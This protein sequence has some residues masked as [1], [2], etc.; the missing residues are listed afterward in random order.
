MG[1]WRLAER[2]AAHAETRTGVVENAPTR[3]LATLREHE[4]SAWLADE[5]ESF[6]EDHA[7]RGTAELELLTPRWAD[8]PTP[9]LSSFQSYARNPEQNS[10]EALVDR[11]RLDREAAQREV[12]AR[13]TA[14][15]WERAF[16]LRRAV[17]RH[18]AHWARRYAPL[19]EN[20]KAAVL[21]VSH[22]TR[23]L[24]R[25]RRRVVP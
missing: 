3:L 10:V 18:Y 23:K 12:D 21:T 8:D 4:G 2:A 19:R 20:P 24:L 1:V 17:L 15:W 7:H 9:V 25:A 5:L 14:H 13:L 11:Q 22:E 16:P 6:L